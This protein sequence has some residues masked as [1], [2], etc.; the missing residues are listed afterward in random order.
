MIGNKRKNADKGGTSWNILEY[1]IKLTEVGEDCL[2]LEK[3]R[4]TM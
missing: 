2:A 3:M 4:L 1:Y